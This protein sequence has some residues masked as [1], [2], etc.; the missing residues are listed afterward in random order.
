M[1]PWVVDRIFRNLLI[2]VTGNTH[3]AEFCIDKLYDPDSSGG[4][5]GLVELRAFEMP[6]HG[7]MSLTQQ[8]LLRAL[9]AW[10]WKTPYNLPLVRWGTELH[11]RFML[12]HFVAQDFDDVVADLR[13]SGYPLE[14]AWFAPHLE[15]RFPLYGTVTRR[16]VHLELRQA[17][18][19]WHVMGEEG[20][21]GATVRHVDSSVERLQVKM[22]GLTGSRHVVTCNGR[23]VPLHPTGTVGEFVAGV[24]YRAWQP[25]SGLHPT[26]PV[27]APLVFDLLD[28]WSERSM[29]GCVYHVAHPGGRNF[30]V[31][32]VNAYEAESRRLARFFDIG[33]TGGSGERST[34]G[35]R[36]G[37]PVDARPADPSGVSQCNPRPT[38]NASR[39]LGDCSRG[40]SRCRAPTTRWSRR[41]A[42]YVHIARGSFARSKRSGRDEFTSRW[43]GARRSIRENGVTYNV[44]GDPQG[45]DRPWELDMVPLLISPAEWAGLETALIQ[46]TRLLN[47][48]L[49]DLYGPQTLLGSGLLPPS[50][51]LSNPAFLRAC[52]GIPVPHGMYLHLHAVDL[53]R[54]PDGQWWVLADRTQAPSGAGYALENR[55][56]LLR[57]LPEAFRDCQVHRLA[58]FFGAQRD[59]LR[60]MAPQPRDQPRVVLLTPGPYNET[61][62]EHAYLARYLGFTLVEG[63]DLTVRDR[64]VFIKTLE[65]LQPVDVIFR[66]LDDSFCDPL[67]LR[68]D[69]SLGVAGLV[70]AARAGNVTIANAL[71]SG[72]IETAAIMPFLPG[73]CRHLLGEELKL[74]SFATWWGGQPRELEY[75]IEHLDQLVVKRAFPTDAREPVFGAELSD[76][77]RSLL[78]AELRARPDH[79]VGQEHVAL[80]AAP[81][82]HQDRMEPRRVVLRTYVAAAGDSYAVMPGGLTRVSS[83]HDGPIVSMQRGGG[84][85]DTWVLSDGPVSSMTLLAPAGSAVRP[86]R[87]GSDLPSRVAENLFWLGRHAER[88]EHAIRLLRSVVARL[89]DRDTTDPREL[90]ALLHVLVELEML[91]ERFAEE[92]PL[93]QLEEEMLSFIVKEN[94]HARLRQH[95]ER[96]PPDRHHRPRPAVDR[97]LADSEPAPPGPPP[98][99]RPPPLRR[100]PGALESDD[101]GPFRVQRHGDGEHDA[102]PRLALPGRRPPSRTGDERDQ[103]GP[104]GARGRP[105]GQRGARA[106]ARDRRQLDDLPPS[107]FRAA[108]ARA[109]PGSVAARR[110]QYPRP[111]V[112]TGRRVG[113]RSAAC[114]AIPGPRRRRGRNG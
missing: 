94:P 57:S 65:G 36:P 66:R 52:H 45:V 31:F 40:T 62:F 91:P 69:S 114:P 58:S 7:R 89:T 105:R 96:A 108:A 67:E 86:E 46:R 98:A 63:G 29:G 83:T 95:A 113:S 49:A 23:R 44:Y 13:R 18:E 85:K 27:Q 80:S 97:H 104:A 103:P 10:F 3:R 55:I 77:E 5:Q 88:A 26:I 39:P 64:R 11:D 92:M 54:S 33:H 12:P 14:T 32:P 2:D 72:V 37:L 16:G 56:V 42:C 20:F 48:I 90:S 53:V 22:T 19:P 34:R 112:S 70:E 43:E 81:V 60:A 41:R 76:G 30:E 24:R 73:L 111:G 71:G 68:S 107:L 25:P 78:A 110:H 9:I 4:R 87:A 6:P 102:R 51:V 61:Y 47:L 17:L 8:L 59:T 38:L 99:T 82:W 106:A 74:P 100:R 75:V 109:R 21:A 1:S 79:F 93:R 101:H 84:S 35:A 15:F 28:T 50:L